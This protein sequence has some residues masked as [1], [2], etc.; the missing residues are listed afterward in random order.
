MRAFAAF[1]LAAILSGTSGAPTA[2]AQSDGSGKPA[3]V[4]TSLRLRFDEGGKAHEVDR[5]NL[6]WYA[7]ETDGPSVPIKAP[8]YGD[9][10]DGER[11]FVYKP[12]VPAPATVGSANDIEPGY[13]L[14]K[15]KNLVLVL[16]F[17]KPIPSAKISL[18]ARG[19]RFSDWDGQLLN[20]RLAVISLHAGLKNLDLEISLAID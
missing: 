5:R 8:F 17:E 9:C 15:S 12:R 18:L 14:Q 13:C 3:G 16:V 20:D 11:P 2:S 4:A 6:N 19:S 10:A 1:L 7:V